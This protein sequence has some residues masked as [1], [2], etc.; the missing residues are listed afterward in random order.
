MIKKYT[1]LLIHTYYTQWGKVITAPPNINVI[2]LPLDRNSR[3]LAFVMPPGDYALNKSVVGITFLCFIPT[4][5]IQSVVRS[6][7]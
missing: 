4:F 3:C 5:L 1:S 2:H 7:K 6:N